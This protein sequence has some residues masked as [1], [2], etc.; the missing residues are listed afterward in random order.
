M[1]DTFYDPNIITIQYDSHD[2]MMFFL[3]SIADLFSLKHLYVAT[4]ALSLVIIR[5]YTTI[6]AAYNV[7]NG[8][9][10]SGYYIG[11]FVI[12]SLF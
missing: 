8:T 9:S 10:S 7:I 5:L 11:K 1:F 3:C 12:K 6:F 2:V 4:T